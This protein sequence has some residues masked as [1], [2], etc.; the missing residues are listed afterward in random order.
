M[1]SHAVSE[2]TQATS[3]LVQ[4]FILAQG[5]RY[6][7]VVDERRWTRIAVLM[8]V[9]TARVTG[10]VLPAGSFLVLPWDVARADLLDAYLGRFAAAAGPP[11]HVVLISSRGTLDSD[12]LRA[13]GELHRT[14]I[15]ALDPVN[16][17][18]NGPPALRLAFGQVLLGDATRTLSSVN[19]LKHMTNLGDPRDPRVFFERLRRASPGAPLTR[20]L[21]IANVLVFV[22]MKLSGSA[23][24]ARGLLEGLFGGFGSHTLVRWGANVGSLTVGRDEFWRLLACTFLHGDLLHIGFNMYALKILGDTAERLFGSSMFAAIYFISAL[25]G[26]LASLGFTLAGNPMLPSV[27]ASGAVFGIMGGLLGFALSRRGSVPTQVSRG[28]TRSAL[29]FIGVNV[30][31]GFSVS[32]IDNSAHLGGLAAGLLSGLALSR[33]LPPARQPSAGNRTMTIVALSVGLLLSYVLAV[34]RYTPDV[35]QSGP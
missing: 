9:P 13:L 21:L 25:G 30:A 14:Q 31:I 11:D 29:L 15:A 22:V 10:S 1:D 17:T 8:N 16:E 7:S 28:L 26:S 24:P 2:S 34:S 32:F 18:V 12:S 19:P 27:G 20:A 23:D 33:D 6:A 5:G 35:M 4:Q 3:A